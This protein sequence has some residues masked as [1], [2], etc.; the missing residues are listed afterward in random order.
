MHQLWAQNCSAAGGAHKNRYIMC[1][2]CIKTRCTS[3]VQTFLWCQNRLN[4]DS[5]IKDV[6]PEA[7]LYENGTDQTIFF[8]IFPVI[9][10]FYEKK[11]KRIMIF[12]KL[13]DFAYFKRR[14]CLKIVINPVRGEGEIL[15]FYTSIQTKYCIQKFYNVKIM[16]IILLCK[17]RIFLEY[18]NWNIHK[19]MII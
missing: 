18:K 2:Q 9:I 17:C 1:P 6:L 13:F 16:C 12:N 14:L 4:S 15:S 11:K 10:I 3:C 8:A 7:I 5:K 19:C